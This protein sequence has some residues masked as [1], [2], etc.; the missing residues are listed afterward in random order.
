M[1]NQKFS[2]TP[3]HPYLTPFLV[4]AVIVCF[5]FIY[6]ISEEYSSTRDRLNKILVGESEKIEKTF[7]NVID[8]TAFVMKIIAMQ[9]KPNFQD[10]KHIYDVISKYTVNPK[11]HN[12]L[13]WTVFTWVD[14]KGITKVDSISGI[15]TKQKDMS[16][17][18]YIQKTKIFPDILHLGKPNFGFTSQRYIIPAAMG[19]YNEGSYIGALTIGFDLVQLSSILEDSI[20]SKDIYYAILDSNFDTITQSP[21]N[22]NISSPGNVK[23]FEIKD[24]VKEKNI[25]F[26]SFEQVSQINLFKNGTNHYLHK[27]RDYPYAIYL[28]YNTKLVRNL[29]WKDITFRV[30]E[31]LV[32]GL[33]AFIVVILIYNREKLLREK[34]E[35]SQQDAEE[36]SQAKT[37]FLAYTAHELRSPLAYIIS[38]S[39]IIM[40]NVFGKIPKKYQLYIS[41][42]NYSSKEL[43]EFI[44]GLLN[45]MRVKKGN[46]DVTLSDVSIK[47][48]LLRSIKINSLNYDDKIRFEVDGFDN[49]PMLKS[50]P[51]RLIQIFNNIISNAIKYSPENSTLKILARLKLSGIKIYFIDSGYGMSEEDVKLSK[52]KF[53]ITGSNKNLPAE[54]SVGLGL[55]LV[56]EL[57]GIL[58]GKFDIRSKV[59]SGTEIT[60]FFPKKLLK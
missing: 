54:K 19:Q 23:N 47:E 34:A 9:I 39:E 26:Q 49:L 42:I 57:V 18:Y 7:A 14:S 16:S 37:N 48:V 50:D 58:G 59:G 22:I 36:A 15:K 60:I 21:S 2:E 28:R 45:E 55:P 10:N 24:F 29:F 30:V 52:I 40:N 3:S 27:L 25:D 5:L 11:L 43:L 12:V 13:S 56:I 17:K 32:I 35:K 38:S 44:D 6:F 41:N 46:F 8:H 1:K 4:I 53:G 33:I 31:I 20:Q 51:K